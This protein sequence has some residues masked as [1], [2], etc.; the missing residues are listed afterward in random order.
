MLAERFEIQTNILVTKG[1]E[2]LNLFTISGPRN[3]QTGNISG[4]RNLKKGLE[5]LMLT[6]LFKN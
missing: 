1:N 4:A 3:L 5:N 2:N 6:E